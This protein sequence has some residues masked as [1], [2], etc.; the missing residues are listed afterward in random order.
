MKKTLILILC[1]SLLTGCVS[2]PVLPFSK[3][4][5]AATDIL[6]LTAAPTAQLT[7]GVT[8]AP[9]PAPMP[10]KEQEDP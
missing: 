9:T 1:L 6:I 7:A 3:A 4:E 8:A 10:T 5:P 2:V